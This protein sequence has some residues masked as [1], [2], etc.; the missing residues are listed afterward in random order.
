M[1]WVRFLA[2]ARDF[3]LFHNIQTG[4]GA[5]P[6]SSPAGTEVL[7]LGVKRPECEAD[8]YLYLMP[9]SRLVE[10]HLQSSVRLHGV[11]PNLFSTGTTLR[12]PLLSCHAGC[13]IRLRQVIPKVD[14][15]V[16]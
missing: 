10:L 14:L 1:A 6:A 4:C 13:I 3:S 5:H 8:H 9:M 11:V 2:G 16:I 7:L 15:L 12:L